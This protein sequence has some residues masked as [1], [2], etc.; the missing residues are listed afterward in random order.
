MPTITADDVPGLFAAALPT[1]PAGDGGE[2]DL[3]VDDDG[4][5]LHYLDAAERARHLVERLAAGAMDEVEAAFALIERMH[6]EG[7]AYVRELATIGYLEDIQNGLLRA[8]VPL[9]VIEPLLGPES[10]R[11]WRGV[12]AF[13]R[14]EAPAVLPVD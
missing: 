2:D 5:R 9:A 14:G 3:H 4:T 12:E 8:G 1:W 7:D 6:V 10:V 11:W 13:W